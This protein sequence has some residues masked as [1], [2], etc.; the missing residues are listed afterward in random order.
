MTVLLHDGR[1]PFTRRRPQHR[2][3]TPALQ[4]LP[5]HTSVA[6]ATG[7]QSPSASTPA[8]VPY[9]HRCDASPSWHTTHPESCP[10]PPCPHLAPRRDRLG[11]RLPLPHRRSHHPARTGPTA[12]S[13][14]GAP[15]RAFLG[16]SATTRTCTYSM[17]HRE[18]LT[19][20][21]STVTLDAKAYAR[22]IHRMRGADNLRRD[23]SGP[24]S[25]GF[26]N[27]RKP[28]RAR[29]EWPETCVC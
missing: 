9:G 7:A 10:Y 24:S 19:P 25:S 3:A 4:P 27:A 15:T 16:E 14:V 29:E 5:S 2:L 28:F 6:A 8:R 18:P 1:Q 20:D 13:P 22:T 11:H 23:R 26:A 17:S 12:T 21:V